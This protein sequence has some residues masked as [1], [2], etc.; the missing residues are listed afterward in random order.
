MALLC[1]YS[2]EEKRAKGI[3]RV[4][5]K[6]DLRFQC[7]KNTLFNETQMRSSMTLLRHH[8]H[9]L[10][11]ETISKTGLSAF[12]DK[13]YLLNAVDSYAYGHHNIKNQLT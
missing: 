10:Y 5:V 8:S 7:Y 12:D 3:S 4:T 9:Q 6:K 1:N 13:R 11:S 2:N